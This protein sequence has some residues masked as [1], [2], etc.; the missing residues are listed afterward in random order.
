MS[1]TAA[2]SVDNARL[3]LE[4]R[5]AA[6][7]ARVWQAWTEPEQLARWFGPAE[8]ERIEAVADVRPGGQYD[9]VMH[10]GDGG[11]HRVGGTYIEVS[12]PTRL[13]FTWAW[14]ST[15][16][17]ESRVT[18]E[19]TAIAEGTALKLVHERFHDNETAQRHAEGWC[20]S[21]VKLAALVD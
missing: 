19:F 16:E 11:R 14:H 21:L 18:V 6:S 1:A 10:Q 17:R 15:P 8:I 4:R 2:D 20:S 7:P 13:V 5:L 3:V 12:P 9:I